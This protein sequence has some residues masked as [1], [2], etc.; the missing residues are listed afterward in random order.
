ML[1][2]WASSLLFCTG[3]STPLGICE[4]ALG[5]ERL[6]RRL[7]TSWRLPRIAWLTGRDPSRTFWRYWPM[8]RNRRCSPCKDCSWFVILVDR[9]PTATSRMS[10]SKCS[11]PISSASSASMIEGVCTK[12]LVVVVP[13]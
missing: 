8:S 3:A 12:V 2:A 1:I 9:V 10:L 6:G 13:S 4:E 7:K 11:T 5:V